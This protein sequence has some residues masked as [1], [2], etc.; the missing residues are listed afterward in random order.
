[1]IA[2][3]N[4]TDWVT[5]EKSLTFATWALVIA[6]IALVMDSWLKGREQ[7]KRWD[8]EDQRSA[9]QTELQLARWKEEDQQRHFQESPHVA[10]GLQAVDH[11][12][13]IWCANVG[14]VAFVIESVV[15]QDL[16][17]QTME[18]SEVSVL[19]SGSLESFSLAQMKL[20]SYYGEKVF[21]VRLRIKVAEKTI[22]TKPS[23]FTLNIGFRGDLASVSESTGEQVS[24][25]C[26]KCEH[27][28]VFQF[29]DASGLKELRGKL[30]EGVEQIA[31]VCPNHA[32]SGLLW[33]MDPYG[34][35]YQVAE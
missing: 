23:C 29:D 4:V 14:A 32:A 2:I 27:I 33:M 34:K 20:A 12:L 8:S 19:P 28:A 13:R 15:L 1:M 16:N 21:E 17:G 31:A 25:M 6:T 26:P 9:E 35:K 11:K 22:E 24:K 3:E 30:A 10:F 7:Q 18:H 5:S